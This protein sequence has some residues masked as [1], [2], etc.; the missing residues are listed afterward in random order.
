MKIG[1]PAFSAER[2]SR[3]IF[4][5]IMPGSGSAT[6]SS[7]C[8]KVRESGSP[9]E[10]LH[11]R[12]KPPPV[13]AVRERRSGARS[14]VQSPLAMKGKFPDAASWPSG[15][16]KRAG[17]SPRAG[18]RV[19][20]C[21]ARVNAWERGPEIRGSSAGDA[22]PA[23]GAS[24]SE[25]PPGEMSR[26]PLL[27]SAEVIGFVNSNH[28]ASILRSRSRKRI[29]SLLLNGSQPMSCSGSH[30]DIA[31]THDLSCRKYDT[32]WSNL[33][34]GSLPRSNPAAASPVAP[35]AAGAFV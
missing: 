28:R 25:R 17:S 12:S 34:A 3:P 11:R 32:R 30:H 9:G 20:W 27:P 31:W 10:P 15:S 6:R 8:W 7:A 33:S 13:S 23:G 19:S 26:L 2:M 4:S 16:R 24:P 21:R 22:L 14:V 1:T 29:D 35:P 18:L 5:T